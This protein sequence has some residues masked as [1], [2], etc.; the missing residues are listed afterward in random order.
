MKITECD[1]HFEQRNRLAVTH[2]FLNELN[3]IKRTNEAKQK[4]ECKKKKLELKCLSISSGKRAKRL[5]LLFFF[6]W[7]PVWL[8]CIQCG[9]VKW[10]GIHFLWLCRQQKKKNIP[11]TRILTSP[12]QFI[13]MKKGVLPGENKQQFKCKI[14]WNE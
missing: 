2:P 1:I 10:F 4:N 12:P 11:L 13:C 14:I 9:Y 3:R 8:S 6:I 5:S 7:N